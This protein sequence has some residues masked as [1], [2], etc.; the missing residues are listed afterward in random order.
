MKD[1]T[2]QSARKW[3]IICYDIKV[4]EAIIAKATRWAYILHDR[5]TKPDG[6]PKPPHYHVYVYRRN[7]TL[8]SYFVK[9]GALT[10]PDNP[11]VRVAI[12]REASDAILYFQHKTPEAIA[13][14]KVPYDRAEISLDKDDEHYLTFAEASAQ[15]ASQHAQ[16]RAQKR[17]ELSAENSDFLNDL[18][19]HHNNPAFMFMRY[20]WDYAINRDRYER[21]R[22]A[23]L[24]T[25][26][27]ELQGLSEAA[28]ECI[29]NEQPPTLDAFK[30]DIDLGAMLHELQLLEAD[31]RKLL[32]SK[33][34]DRITAV[35]KLVTDRMV[36]TET[37]RG[38]CLIKNLPAYDI[39]R[40]TDYEENTINSYL[41]TIE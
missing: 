29:A 24:I 30:Y 10:S 35:S 37:I 20:G 31:T 33:H 27:E 6:T 14:N 4:V 13:E 15:R 40:G 28:L 26:L 12:Q 17:A 25:P 36:L 5:D 19:L 23:I 2:Q 7:D 8:G 1:Y 16:K 38:Y 41:A 11:T 18:I 22:S 39:F 3:H 21:F 32:L 34:P 9:L